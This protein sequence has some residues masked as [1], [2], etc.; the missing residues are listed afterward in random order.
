MADSL[1]IARGDDILNRAQNSA[2][3]EVACGKNKRRGTESAP[4]QAGTKIDL[5]NVDRKK[6]IPYWRTWRMS[7]P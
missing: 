5:N 1:L 7:A 4:Y 6:K 2:C 3:D